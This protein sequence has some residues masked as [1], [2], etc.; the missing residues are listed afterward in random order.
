LFNN[1]L[2]AHRNSLNL[3]TFFDKQNPNVNLTQAIKQQ[4]HLYKAKI[5]QAK[6]NL[7]TSNIENHTNKPIVIWNIINDS[8]IIRQTT[9]SPNE[10]N[11][12]FA[13]ISDT[14]STNLQRSTHITSQIIHNNP[15][16]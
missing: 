15:Y 3:L 14:I 7:F 16:S 13:N 6:I 10:L 1:E 9:L 8:K 12:F 5:I 11:T 4:K 2:K